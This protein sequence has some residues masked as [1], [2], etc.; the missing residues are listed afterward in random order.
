MD[1][2]E[3]NNWRYLTE[4]RAY[5]AQ[6]IDICQI[7]VTISGN[8]VRNTLDY[9][10]E[11]N[12]E[13]LLPWTH[14]LEELWVPLHSLT[15]KTSSFNKPS[16]LKL[17]CLFLYPTHIATHYIILFPIWRSDHPP[18]CGCQAGISNWVKPLKKITDQR[19]GQISLDI[20]IFIYCLGCCL[21]P[22]SLTL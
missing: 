4:G 5:R 8:M 19:F 6:T 18:P 3:T 20:D 9:L 22:N 11:Q 12:C 21:L 15:R 2:K 14:T 13:L 1:E 7:H 10:S 16:T 17:I